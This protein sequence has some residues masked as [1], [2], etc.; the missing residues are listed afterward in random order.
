MKRGHECIDCEKE[1]RE[2][3]RRIWRTKNGLKIKQYDRERSLK[4]KER[5]KELYHKSRQ[6][7]IK[8]WMIRSIKA[9]A[10]RLNIPFAITKDDIQIPKICPVLGIELKLGVGG[11]KPWSP[12]VDRIIPS[13]GYIK[14]NISV[15][16][17]R[18]NE[19]KHNAS[20]EELE[21]VLIYMRR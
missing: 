10:K 9:R 12:S 21:K 8:G 18:A 6:R 11:V 15:I 20:I 17:W 3:S 14:G 16:S 4:N 1:R 13:L 7:D 19:L 2:N 5:N